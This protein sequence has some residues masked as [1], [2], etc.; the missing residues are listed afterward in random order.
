MQVV[1]RCEAY[2]PT[3]AELERFGPP[4]RTVDG[5]PYDPVYRRLEPRFSSV[6]MANGFPERHFRDAV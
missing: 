3:A 1:G 4:P 5:E 6:H 2:E